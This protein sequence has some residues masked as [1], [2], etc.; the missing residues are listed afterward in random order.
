MQRFSNLNRRTLP[1]LCKSCGMLSRWSGVDLYSK[2]RSLGASAGPRSNITYITD[3]CAQSRIRLSMLCRRFMVCVAALSL[4]LLLLSACRPHCKH[5]HA[6]CTVCDSCRP[7]LLLLQLLQTVLYVL[8]ACF[9][10]YC[11]CRPV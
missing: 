6:S 2:Y 5:L 11:G 3:R 4:S 10:L 7:L 9:M 1:I 8:R